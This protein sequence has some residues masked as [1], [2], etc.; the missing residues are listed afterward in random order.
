MLGVVYYLP[1]IIFH[2]GS[3]FSTCHANLIILLFE[4]CIFIKA[5]VQTLLYSPLCFPDYFYMFRKFD[6]A[7]LPFL[8]KLSK[9]EMCQKG[10]AV[11]WHL[12]EKLTA[13]A[14]AEQGGNCS[15]IL[16][17]QEE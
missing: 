11:L 10:F 3:K 14:D 17:L 2:F 16:E 1:L 13:F 15:C 9:L 8:S 12:L 4:L 5:V 7:E 6:E